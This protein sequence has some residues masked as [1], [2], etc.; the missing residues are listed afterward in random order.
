M[1]KRNRLSSL[2]QRVRKGRLELRSLL[3]LVLLMTLLRGN[4]QQG[5]IFILS[6]ELE[7]F[8][9]LFTRTTWQSRMIRFDSP[10][11]VPEHV[12]VMVNEGI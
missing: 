2:A 11:L 3:R 10:L 12:R 8:G 4:S 6:E 7:Y 1:I 9:F 5:E